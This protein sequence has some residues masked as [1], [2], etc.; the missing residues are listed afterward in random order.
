MESSGFPGSGPQNTW[1]ESPNQRKQHRP[2]QV[3]GR[4]RL[5]HRRQLASTGTAKDLNKRGDPLLT[6]GKQHTYGS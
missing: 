2:P 6:E 1:R 4:L 5:L 3:F